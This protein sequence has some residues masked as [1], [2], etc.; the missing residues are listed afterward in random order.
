[1]ALEGTFQARGLGVRPPQEHHG[2]A[3]AAE[4]GQRTTA[5]VKVAFSFKVS[6]WAENNGKW[7]KSCTVKINAYLSFSFNY[8]N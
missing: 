7:E 4:K 8:Q 1:M 6:Y 2:A 5:T 3:V